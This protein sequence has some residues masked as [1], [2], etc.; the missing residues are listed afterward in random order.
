VDGLACAA[1]FPFDSI[2]C[3][4]VVIIVWDAVSFGGMVV[5]FGST[6]VYR[7][8]GDVRVNLFSNPLL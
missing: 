7:R 5:S 2:A 6:V 3:A 1:V 4:H 8:F